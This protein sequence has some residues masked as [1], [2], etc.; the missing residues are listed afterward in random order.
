MTPT[1][2]TPSARPARPG[3]PPPPGPRRHDLDGLRA[4]A[5]LLGIALHAALAFAPI[6]WLAMN[7]ET[8][9]LMIPFF[10]IIHGFRLPLF[11]LMS[12]FFSAMLLQRR[13]VGGF[14]THRWKRIGL[15]LLLGS[16]TIIPA[17]WGV[18]IGGTALKSLVP[19]PE[20]EWGQT[21]SSATSI[22]RAA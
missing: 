18:I 3:S 17:M 6:P 11:F 22:W 10:E 7:R 4:F 1:P 20:R 16:V 14:L 2:D 5:M 9:T 21:D 13:G 12:G 8:S 15:P 19:A